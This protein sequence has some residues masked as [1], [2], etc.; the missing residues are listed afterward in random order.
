M[1]FEAFRQHSLLLISASELATHKTC[2]T[3]LRVPEEGLKLR[4]PIQ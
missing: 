3:G 4:V 2:G 1:T